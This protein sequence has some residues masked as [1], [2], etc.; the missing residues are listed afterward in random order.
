MQKIYLFESTDDYLL[1]SAANEF[2]K[3]HHFEAFNVVR[4]NF[5]DTNPLDILN[6]LQTISLL[7]EPKLIILTNPEF[8]KANYKD[9]SVVL[10]FT[11]YFK[12]KA[13]EA[14]LL[15]LATFSLDM[16]LEINKSLDM[17]ASIKRID[18]VNDLNKWV[19]DYLINKGYTI[20]E[21]A[22]NLLLERTQNEML[23]I[24]NELEKLMLYVETKQIALNDVMTLVSRPLDDNIY[25]LLAAFVN[26]DSKRLLAIYQDFM[27]LNEDEMRIINAISSKLEEILYTKT[28]MSQG[29]TKDEIASYLRVKSGRAYYMMQNAKAISNSNLLELSDIITKLDYDIKSGKIDKKLGLELFILGVH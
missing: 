28:L 12:Q 27:L 14:I 19:N 2:I 29:L 24:T 15:I 22:L 17:C 13:H 10:A 7:G 11:N 3:E 21:S 20:E 4:Y 25:D 26:H 5:L 16:N 6:D 23:V 9:S 18:A 1:Q 8:L